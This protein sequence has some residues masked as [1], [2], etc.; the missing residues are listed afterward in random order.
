MKLVVPFCKQKKY[1]NCLPVS[2]KMVLMF[3]GYKIKLSELEDVCGTDI[4]GTDVDRAADNLRAAGYTIEIKNLNLMGLKTHLKGRIPV[5]AIVNTYYFPRI[6]SFSSHA[7][8][9]AGFTEN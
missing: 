3:F 1:Y 4:T 6:K 9:V 8:V 5:I 2:L 7:V